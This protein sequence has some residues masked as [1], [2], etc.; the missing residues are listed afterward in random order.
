MGPW[1]S[2][3]GSQIYRKWY[4]DWTC[5]VHRFIPHGS[6]KELTLYIDWSYLVP[7][8]NPH[9]TVSIYLS[10]CLSLSLSLCVTHTHTHTHSYWLS[11]AWLCYVIHTHTQSHTHTH[12]QTNKHTFIKIKKKNHHM[13]LQGFTP[14]PSVAMSCSAAEASMSIP[15]PGQLSQRRSM[16]TVSADDQNLKLL[17]RWLLFLFVYYVKDP[18]L[19]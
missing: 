4:L 9:C 7:W 14:V 10:V 15:L 12:K 19:L 17:S 11:H 2:T 1:L 6:W 8:Y 5:M 18:D 16:Q 13:W 3:D